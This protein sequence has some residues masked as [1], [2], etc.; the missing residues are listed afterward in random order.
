MAHPVGNV[1]FQADNLLD[2]NT[3]LGLVTSDPYVS[4]VSSNILNLTF[5]V[6][7]S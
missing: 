1:T 7:F 2:F 5:V 6:S 3:L 4:L